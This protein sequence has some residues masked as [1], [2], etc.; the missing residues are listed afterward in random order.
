MAE[1]VLIIINTIDAG[2][3]ETFVMKVFR[4]LYKEYTFDFL[5]NKKDSDY[6]LKEINELGGQVYYGISKSQNVLMS[7]KST[8]RTVKNGGYKKVLC[9]SV[10][11]LGCLDLLACRIAGAKLCLTRSTNS[12]AGGKVSHVLAAFCRPFMRLLTDVML[13]PSKEAGIW[14]FGNKAVKKGKVKIINNG[15][16]TGLYEYNEKKRIDK[17]KELGLEEKDFVVGHVG[18]FN[19]QKNH[20]KLIDIFYEVLKERQS[21]KLLLVG[22]GELRSEIESKAEKLGI[23]DKILF[24]GIRDDVPDILMVMDVFVF[25]SLYEGMPNAVI[26]AQATGLPCVVAD[27]ISADVRI[28]HC[29]EMVNL[30]TSSLYWAERIEGII[31]EHFYDDRKVMINEIVEAGYSIYSTADL[32]SNELRISC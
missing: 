12:S 15:L 7:M 9:V 25:P 18:R 8:Y 32:L 26:E 30:G 5:I 23:R 27:T 3:A 21:A 17:R 13:A 20:A 24:L 14:L 1:K 31:K 16:D 6:Y 2:G 4:C 29:L 28:T 19:K 10:H 22:D 11:P